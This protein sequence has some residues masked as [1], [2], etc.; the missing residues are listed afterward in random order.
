MNKVYFLG[1]L[2]ALCDFIGVYS[3]HRGNL[4]EREAAKVAATSAA[5]EAKLEAER[6]AQKAAM[7]D[8]IHAAEQRKV[9]KAAKEAREKTD[10]ETRQLALDAR[11]KTYREQEKLAR[12]IERLKKDIEA[13]RAAIAKIA[14]ERQAADSEKAFLLDFVSKA[15]TNVQALQSLLNKLNTSTPA[16]ASAA[17]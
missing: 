11:D 6:V 10:R 12:Q 15:Q 4:K 17:K 2:A 16:P 1:P 8:A 5:R 9:E 7:A 3:V 14:A 13:E